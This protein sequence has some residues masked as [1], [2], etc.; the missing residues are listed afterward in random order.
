MLS[1][2]EIIRYPPAPVRASAPMKTRLVEPTVISAPTEAAIRDY[3]YH[4][5]EQSGCVPGRDLDNW[6]EASA[7]LHHPTPSGHVQPGAEPAFGAPSQGHVHAAT[8]HVRSVQ[9]AT[10]HTSSQRHT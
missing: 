10:A 9:E 5:Y 4:L 7:A 8:G 6:L 3:A 2:L 1:S